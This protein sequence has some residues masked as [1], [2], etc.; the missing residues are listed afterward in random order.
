MITY[1]PSLFCGF[2]VLMKSPYESDICMKS[3]FVG[4][5]SMCLT[6]FMLFYLEDVSVI[7]GQ[8]FFKL[9]GT[10]SKV[11]VFLLVF[12]AKL[13]YDRYWDGKR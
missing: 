6:I 10:Y 8:N 5:V 1:N 11:L 7:E 9:Y 12:R 2:S 3:A 4:V 13:A